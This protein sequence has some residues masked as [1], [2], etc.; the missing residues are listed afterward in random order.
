MRSVELGLS[1]LGRTTM[2]HLT[3]NVR[4]NRSTALQ[5]RRA[6]GC[7][8]QHLARS[9][10][11]DPEI[12]QQCK[13]KKPEAS[14]LSVQ[15]LPLH[16][17]VTFPSLCLCFLFYKMGLVGYL[18]H[19][20]GVHSVTSYL[21]GFSCHSATASFEQLLLLLQNACQGLSMLIRPGTGLGKVNLK[22]P[23]GS[24]RASAPCMR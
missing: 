17:C 5:S 23:S 1:M 8:R 21:S 14:R 24:H 11:W 15:A 2:D 22:G 13:G 7:R 6:L 9:N 18:P 19:R 4:A 10:S 20:T 3:L 16:S 12:T